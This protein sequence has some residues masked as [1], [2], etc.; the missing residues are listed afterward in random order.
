MPLASGSYG[1]Y[2]A[3]K[4]NQIEHKHRNNWNESDI[5]RGQAVYAVRGIIS[6]IVQECRVLVEEIASHS[7]ATVT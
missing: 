6:K 5:V 2:G 3:P 1:S 7:M 4:R